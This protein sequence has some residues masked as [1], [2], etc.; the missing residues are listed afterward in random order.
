MAGGRQRGHPHPAAD[1]DRLAVTDRGP[2]EGDLVLGVDV[3]RRAGALG[4]SEAAGDVV[5]VD[6][7][8]EDVG[9]PHLVLL[10]Q[11]QDA[12]DVALRVDHEGDLAVVDHVAAVAERGRLDR[13]DRQV[14][15][16]QAGSLFVSG[17]SG[18]TCA[19]S[20]GGTPRS[21]PVARIAPR[22]PCR[23]PR[24]RRRTRTR[25]AGQ[26]S[27]HCGCPRRT[28]RT[29][30][31]LV[32]LSQPGGQLPHR[33]QGRARHV[34]GDVLAR[35]ADVHHG[36][37][38]RSGTLKALDSR[39]PEW[40]DSSSASLTQV[41]PDTGRGIHATQHTHPQGYYQIAVGLRIHDGRPPEY[42]GGYSRSSG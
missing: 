1:L 27:R 3:V 32:Q 11:V 42:H 35:F 36:G 21:R 2:L 12:V 25:A 10:Q 37:A 7:G 30:A 28:R 18:S 29:P 6:V 17:R 33:H 39:S 8:L 16:H 5:V 19:V 14:G 41:V 23:R 31:A 26:S 40:S 24:S 34:A 4:Q 15:A 22:R 9:Q 20:W 13:N 38:V